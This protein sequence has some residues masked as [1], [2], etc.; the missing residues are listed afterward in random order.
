MRIVV[1]M[2][3]VVI[4]VKLAMHLRTPMLQT[5]LVKTGLKIKVL[6]L[7]RFKIETIYYFIEKLIYIAEIF[8]PGVN[9]QFCVY[10]GFGVAT[11][12][13]KTSVNHSIFTFMVAFF[14]FFF[15]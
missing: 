10:H 1:I 15:F 9:L 6:W 14:S 5:R 7:L 12:C 8:S 11:K 2:V 4:M 13:W 3:V